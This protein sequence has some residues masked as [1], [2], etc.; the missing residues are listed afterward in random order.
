MKK[1]LYYFACFA[2]IH[3]TLYPMKKQNLTVYGYKSKLS[4]K[5]K[6]TL[7][8]N[9]YSESLY[10]ACKNNKEKDIPFL[11][12]MGSKKIINKTRKH[13]RTPLYWACKNN[14]LKIVKMLLNKGAKKSINIAET[15]YGC[16]PL[17]KACNNFNIKM[18]KLLLKHGAKKTINNVWILHRPLSWACS[19]NRLNI[20]NLL[21]KY[22][23][24][25]NISS[26]MNRTPLYWAC[27]NSNLEMVKFLTPRCS[28]KTI[29]LSSST[30]SVDIDSHGETPFLLACKN[31]KPEIIKFL[32]PY[33]TKE[34]INKPDT[35]TN[36]TPLGYAIINK[37]LEIIILLLPKCTQKTINAVDK[38][39]GGTLLLDVCLKKNNHLGRLLLKYGAQ[40]TINIAD[41]DGY[42]PL[43]WSI[44][45]Q[46]IDLVT[47]LVE[48]G[49]TIKSEH[50]TYAKNNKIQ[51]YLTLIF[52]FYRTPN[53]IKFIKK[54]RNPKH[55][56][57]DILRVAC[58]KSLQDILYKN[59]KPKLTSFCKLF[60]KSKSEIWLKDAVEKALSIKIKEKTTF[61]SIVIDAINKN[62]F[63]FAET[64]KNKICE[65]IIKD[66][67]F[68]TRLSYLLKNI[69]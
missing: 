49:A 20:A 57:I 35:E 40:A 67:D 45:E 17:Y 51:K 50:Y 27:Y 4:A 55:N 54:Y 53:K 37:N 7:L 2:L 43:N 44:Y 25:P 68:S 63:Y 23:A 66:N 31:N 12:Q 8:N 58:S 60:Q 48:H 52:N 61:D 1:I 3:L 21:I 32:F 11:L 22:G 6:T 62:E 15:K 47:L 64:K 24:N 36:I 41:D 69:N 28:K 59:K 5:S 19:K 29:N 10:T 34:T 46:N 30:D 13:N 16:T 33:C 65:K 56:L 38:E 42:T 14:N 26:Y 9:L 18:I 39:D